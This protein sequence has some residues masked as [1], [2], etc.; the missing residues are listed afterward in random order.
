MSFVSLDL[1]MI[2]HTAAS[3]VKNHKYWMTT[4]RSHEMDILCFGIKSESMKA[5]ILDMFSILNR[6]T[7]KRHKRWNRPG[8]TGTYVAQLFLNSHSGGWSPT[9]STRR[10]GHL[11]A[12]CT[13]SGSLWW[14]SN[15]WNGDW[16]GKP[17]YS[18]KT[19]PSSN[20]PTTNSTWPD[21]CL[22]PGLLRGKPATNRLSYGAACVAQL[23]YSA[24]ILIQE[25]CPRKYV[26]CLKNKK[27]TRKWNILSGEQV[28]AHNWGRQWT[29][30]VI[31]CNIK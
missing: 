21:P 11:L 6:P 12:S 22:N 27:Y 31:T 16:Q 10:D 15:W 5:E 24:Y 7:G 3:S 13:C 1:K 9:G 28:T 23:L 26:V 29:E 19:C 2:T 14:W 20:L 4:R 18:E 30:R 17:K 25:G 8:L